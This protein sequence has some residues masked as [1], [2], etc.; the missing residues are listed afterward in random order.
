MVDSNLILLKQPDVTHLAGQAECGACGHKW[1]AVCPAGVTRFDCPRC[2]RFWGVMRHA[3][4]PLTAWRCHCGEQL[5]WITP[6]GCMCR[7][8]GVLAEGCF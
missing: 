7:R 5:F 4:E 3:V 1:E 6:K 2:D 8:C